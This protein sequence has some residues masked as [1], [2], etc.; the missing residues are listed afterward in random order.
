MSKFLV[1]LGLFALLAV[2]LGIGIH[3]APEKEIIQSPLIGK[4]APTFALPSLTD[5]NRII[6]SQDLRG[7]AYLLNVWGTWCVSCREEHAMLLEV[8]RSKLVPLIGFDW[9]DED[10]LALEWL[11]KL[12]NPYEMVLVDR[13]GRTAID[14]GV[15]GAPETFL[16]NAAGIVSYKHVGPLTEEVWTREFV[17]RLR[18]RVAAVP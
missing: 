7:R 12:G 6:R 18:G 8:S 4:P 11:A 17:P 3:R 5:G 13:E 2:V 15:Y 14:W 1:P 16:V 9:K 10:A